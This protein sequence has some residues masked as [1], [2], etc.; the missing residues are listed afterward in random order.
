MRWD[1]RLWL[2]TEERAYE[3]RNVRSITFDD[4]GCAV[5][6]GDGTVRFDAH[7]VEAFVVECIHDDHV[8]GQ[9]GA[10]DAQERDPHDP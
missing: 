9:E 2:E 4:Q 8:S 6:V 10:E 7:P 5:Q 1:I 3:L